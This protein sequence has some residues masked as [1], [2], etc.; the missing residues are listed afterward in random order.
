MDNLI[1]AAWPQSAIKI[2]VQSGE[3]NQIVA[4]QMFWMPQFEEV[5]TSMLNNNDIKEIYLVGP[6]TYIPK[7]KDK[8][9]ELTNLPIKEEYA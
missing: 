4:Q 2:C 9:E 3:T 1:V 7:V 6:K 8:I 5:F